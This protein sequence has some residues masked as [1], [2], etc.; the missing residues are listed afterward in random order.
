[1]T[2]ARRTHRLKRAAL[3]AFVRTRTTGPDVLLSFDDGPHPEYT[4]AV[5]DRLAAFGI[6]AAFFLVGKR[7]ADPALV[8]RIAAAGHVLG[9]HTFAHL[10]PRWGAVRGPL[11]DVRRCQALVPG[12]TLFRP[13]LGRLTPGLWLAARRLKLR[14][15]NWSLD[16]GDW[17]C[18]SEADALRCAAEVLER[19]RP[20]D[21]VL[22]HDDHR[23]IGPIL[24]GVLPGLVVRGLFGQVMPSTST[25]C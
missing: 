20:G 12:A 7:V 3:A 17:R 18:R 21:I 15:V 24:D 11:A 10:V 9:N 5:L 19:V 6:R 22:F 2:F 8:Q 1:M 23:W 14:C 13:P 25:M 4:P 16:S